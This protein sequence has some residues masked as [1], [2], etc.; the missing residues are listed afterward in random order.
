[1]TKSVRRQCLS[2]TVA[3]RLLSAIGLVCALSTAVQHCWTET[4]V[5]D[6]YSF[7]SSKQAVPAALYLVSQQRGVVYTPYPTVHSLFTDAGYAQYAQSA[8]FY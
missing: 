3:R 4:D 7:D 2:G 1:M 6:V 5:D 8:E